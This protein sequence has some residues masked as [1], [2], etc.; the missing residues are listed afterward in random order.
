M[1]IRKISISL[2]EGSAHFIDQYRRTHAVKSR[3]EVIQH[4]LRLL[5]ERDL[6]QAYR[7]A[8]EDEKEFQ[9]FDSTVADGLDDE[10]W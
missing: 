3:S 8:A 4:A 2:P 9:D 5:R 10:T 6:E 7:E 1:H